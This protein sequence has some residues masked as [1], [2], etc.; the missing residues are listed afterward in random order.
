MKDTT[1]DFKKQIVSITL[2]TFC[3]MTLYEWTKQILFPDITLWWSHA[4][5]I[6]FTALLAF[7]I[8][9]VLL[10]KFNREYRKRLLEIQ[11]RKAT[12]KE[13]AEP[14]P[15]WLAS[16]ERGIPPWIRKSY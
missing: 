13:S 7:N 6:C 10:R 1:P 14:G 11:Q 12:P 3:F 9:Y 4:M 16:Q 2:I 8:S 5:T 15:E